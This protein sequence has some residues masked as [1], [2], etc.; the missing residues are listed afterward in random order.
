MQLLDPIFPLSFFHLLPVLLLFSQHYIKNKIQNIGTYVNEVQALVR[1][2]FEAQASV[3]MS[4][5]A[6]ASVCMSFEAARA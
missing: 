2:S 3:C 1:M 5:E 4:F 6:Q